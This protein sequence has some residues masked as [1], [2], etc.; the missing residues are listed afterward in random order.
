MTTHRRIRRLGRSAAANQRGFSLTETLSSMLIFA[1][2]AAGLT[3]STLNVVRT[4]AVSRDLTTAAA[5]IQ[6]RIEQYRALSFP[7]GGLALSSGSDQI[8]GGGEAGGKFRRT[9]TIT[10]GPS[11]GLATVNVLVSW[12]TSTGARSLRGTAYVCRRKTC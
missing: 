9:W 8:G 3:T 7:A 5:L 4:N 6:D 2:A 12:Q 11:P 10:D 1:I